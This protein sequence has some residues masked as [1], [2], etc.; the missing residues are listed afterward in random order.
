MRQAYVLRRAGREYRLQFRYDYRMGLLDFSLK[1]VS[2]PDIPE[3]KKKE[4]KAARP[5]SKHTK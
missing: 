4:K 5:D 2:V 3:K 1:A